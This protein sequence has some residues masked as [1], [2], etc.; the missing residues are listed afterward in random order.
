MEKINFKKQFGQNF[1]YDTNLLRAIV[2]DAEINNDNVLEIGVGAGTLTKAICEK[3]KKVVSY[4]IDTDLKNQ[5]EETLC[6]E[7]NSLVIYKDF[8]QE[9]N[10]VV[11]NMFE[12]DFK[13]VANLPYYITTPIIFK[14]LSMERI[15]SITI[16]VQKEV[17]E[18]ICAK[19][20]C[21]DY[22]VLS[23]SINSIADTFIK[24][25]VNRNM[26]IPAPNV[27][28]AICLIKINR[29]KYDIKDFNLFNRIVK[30]A[31]H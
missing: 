7:N 16:M 17:A 1:I 9:E 8:L 20:N 31:L 15:T 2:N 18:R 19:S 24:R 12:G 30:S 11:E 4:E 23:V 3:A 5:I 13:V 26:F 29:N 10:S 27:D 6:N 14:L 25:I 28:S 22:G 21:S